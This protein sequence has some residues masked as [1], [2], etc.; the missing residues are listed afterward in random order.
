MV[1]TNPDRDF[2][3]LN[4]CIFFRRA[5]SHDEFIDLSPVEIS[6]LFQKLPRNYFLSKVVSSST[7]RFTL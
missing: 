5:C 2:V 3:A 1:A 6:R 7:H 4:L